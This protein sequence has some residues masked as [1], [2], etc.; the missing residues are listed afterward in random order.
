MESKIPLS[1]GNKASFLEMLC[2]PRVFQLN[3]S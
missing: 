2:W 3:F 1:L